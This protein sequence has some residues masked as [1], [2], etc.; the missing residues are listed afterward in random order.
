MCLRN[1]RHSS[2]TLRAS[3]DLRMQAPPLLLDHI[4]RNRG[5]TTGNFPAHVGQMLVAIAHDLSSLK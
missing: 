2:T 1:W 3:R 4:G 5:T